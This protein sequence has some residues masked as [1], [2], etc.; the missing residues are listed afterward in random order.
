[1]TGLKIVQPGAVPI[2]AKLCRI[3][4][5]AQT[6]NHMVHWKEENSKVSPGLLIE[7]LVICILRHRKPWWSSDPNSTKTHHGRGRPK[8]GTDP[9][10]T[11]TYHIECSVGDMAHEAFDKLRRTES[12]FAL[13][14]TLKDQAKYN[15][16]R[17]LREYKNQNTVETRFRFLKN[18]VYL[19][20]V[21]LKSKKRV[22]AMGYVFILV[23]MLACYLEYRVRKNL[24]ETGEAP[25]LTGN[26]TTGT[27][28]ITTILEVLKT[29]TVAI[30]N[31]QRILPDNL[32]NRAIKMVEWAQV[33]NLT[34]IPKCFL[35]KDKLGLKIIQADATKLGGKVQIFSN[36]TPSYGLCFIFLFYVYPVQI[37]RYRF[38]DLG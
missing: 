28:S 27:P 34:P 7:S 2:V 36:Q 5:I 9:V 6:V 4:N 26:K 24:R 22:Q 16:E 38:Y 23:L 20:P 14:T 8:N 30:V 25:K 37:F 15:D 32:N 35:D 10:V 11:T 29:I 12:T 21:Y 13:I 33:K 3:A 1:M 18:P 17:I 19:G 31:G